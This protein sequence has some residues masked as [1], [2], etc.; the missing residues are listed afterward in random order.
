MKL[1]QARKLIESEATL[2]P[3]DRRHQVPCAFCVR[4]GNGDKSCA[5]GFQETR[6]SKFKGCFAG[7]I[8]PKKGI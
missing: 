3:R 7:T 5:S 6:Y 4:G 8:L 1:E 2:P